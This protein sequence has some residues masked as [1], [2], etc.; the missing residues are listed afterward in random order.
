M[1]KTFWSDTMVSKDIAVSSQQHFGL[2]EQ[3]TKDQLRMGQ[4]TLLR[5]IIGM[6]CAAVIHDS[7][8]GSSTLSIGI[9]VASQEA[10]LAGTLPDPNTA[11]DFPPKGWIFRARGRVFAFPAGAP[12]VYSWRIDRDIRARRVLDNGEPYMILTNDVNESSSV[13][14]RVT[15]LVRCLW[16]VR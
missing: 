13:V 14:L 1:A 9:G 2:I 5:T 12:Q 8:E 10:F 11:N 6:D 3:F 16:L 7:G 4:V 15:G